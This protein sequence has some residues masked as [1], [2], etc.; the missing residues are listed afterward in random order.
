MFISS[1]RF[2]FQDSPWGL[3]VDALKR[4][5]I[6]WV[7]FLLQYCSH[8]CTPYQFTLYHMAMM[9]RIQT[10]C[11]GEVGLR[12]GYSYMKLLNHL[13]AKS[14]KASICF[15][16]NPDANYTIPFC[17]WERWPRAKVTLLDFLASLSYILLELRTI[18]NTSHNNID[19][20]SFPSWVSC[21][22]P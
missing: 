2:Y 22:V 5:N 11:I 17:Y 21:P 1:L 9:D 4:M 13:F 3:P 10:R 18:K 19:Q 15:L 14:N 8:A 16:F 6:H 7:L 20:N 12:L